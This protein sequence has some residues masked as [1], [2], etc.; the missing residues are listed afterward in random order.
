MAESHTFSVPSSPVEASIAPSG[1]NATSFTSPSCPS[2]DR[3]LCPV[4]PSL[5]SR[6]PEFFTPSVT[7]TP[8]GL[9]SRSPPTPGTD[10]RS[11][12]ATTARWSASSASGSTEPSTD[13]V[14]STAS[15]ASRRLSSESTST[16]ATAAAASS[17]APAIL[18]SRSARSLWFV[19]I[20]VSEPAT[21]A[22]TA[23]TAM[24]ARDRRTERRSSATSWVR[25]AL[26]GRVFLVAP[27]EACTEILVIGRRQR[28]ARRVGPRGHL[29]EALS[30]QQEALV[31]VG[32]IPP[33]GGCR[34]HGQRPKVVARLSDP[35]PQPRP[36][37]EQRLV[38][39][40]DRR[41]P[42]RGIPVER[43][44]PVAPERLD[45]AVH[46]VGV[47]RAAAAPSAGR[48]AACPRFPRRASPTGGTAA[49][50]RRAPH[51]SVARRAV[52]RDARAR[53]R[54]RR[55]ADTRR[56][57][58]RPPRGARRAR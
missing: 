37:A 52:P 22:A 32:R 53:P 34:E 25:R 42:R 16:L 3:M 10:V 11:R 35:P 5:M 54:R 49:G 44:E 18:A 43:Q 7:N 24:S 56:V 21:S 4:S 50:M 48:A 19:A 51:R 57:G 15:M 36:D 26:L 8:V 27:G 58:A 39:D 17:L 28:D 20:T 30:P 38:R 46:R 14:C 33:G 6:T 12:N 31:P 2:N 13:R 45:H 1:L 23:N 47:A 55:S 29:L 9:Q 40:L 41:L